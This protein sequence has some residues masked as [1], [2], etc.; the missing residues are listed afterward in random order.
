MLLIG[1]SVHIFCLYSTMLLQLES[2]IRKLKVRLRLA[3]NS[4]VQA[5]SQMEQ[6][7][8]RSKQLIAECEARIN[9]AEQTTARLR[10]QKDE[11]LRE[12]SGQL[13][14]LGAG[15]VKEQKRISALLAHKDDVIA[16]QNRKLNKMRNSNIKMKETIRVFKQWITKNNIMKVGS[17][18]VASEV[19]NN[20]NKH[21][22][23]Y[24]DFPDVFHDSGDIRTPNDVLDLPTTRNTPS[25]R[26][27]RLISTHVTDTTVLRDV[28]RTRSPSVGTIHTLPKQRP[29]LKHSQSHAI[30]QVSPPSQLHNMTSNGGEGHAVVNRG[31]DVIA[32]TPPRPLNKT[33]RQSKSS[34]NLLSEVSSG[35]FTLSVASPSKRTQSVDTVDDIHDTH[36]T[37]ARVGEHFRPRGDTV[38]NMTS[39]RLS[40]QPQT[41]ADAGYDQA[42]MQ[43]YKQHRKGSLPHTMTSLPRE[44]RKASL[45]HNM[46]SLPRDSERRKASLPPTIEYDV[47]S[48]PRH[49]GMRRV[50]TYPDAVF[51]DTE[52]A[53]EHNNESTPALE[54]VAKSK[55]GEG[56][57]RKRSTS[58]PGVEARMAIAAL[59]AD[60]D[61]QRQR[62]RSFE[63]VV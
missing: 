31:Q 7:T 24:L 40:L 48:A 11:E 14:Y 59:R 56:R 36:V 34:G 26:S 60:M 23:E 28:T 57:Q 47:Q 62:I 61:R 20:N 49:G 43:R 4:L 21:Q 33:L 37:S 22:T 53:I 12:L 41:Y 63:E 44:R 1:V 46:A 55:S 27:P 39:R 45:P 38:L 3:N 29:I 30:L 6:Q 16:T 5:R 58:E 18:G 42:S 8:L 2:D 19:N 10:Q 54:A 52:R 13:L 15:L 25:P 9:N 51:Y 32:H 35:A 17:A 50:E